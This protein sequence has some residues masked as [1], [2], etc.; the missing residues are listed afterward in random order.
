MLQAGRSQDRILV[1]WIFSI[2]LVLPA[3]GVDSAL[4][5]ISTRNIPGGKGWLARKADDLT[6][7]CEPTV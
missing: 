7:I 5:Q 3:P 2:Y 6:A 4:T 1:M